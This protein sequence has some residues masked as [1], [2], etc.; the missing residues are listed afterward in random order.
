MELWLFQTAT[1]RAMFRD[2]ERVSQNDD[3]IE[4]RVAAAT[5]VAQLLREIEDR[6]D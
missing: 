1:L 2:A 6:N 5:A 4:R 3:S